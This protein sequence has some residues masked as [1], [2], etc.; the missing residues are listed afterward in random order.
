MLFA[1]LGYYRERF[2]VALNHL[3]YVKY[4]HNNEASDLDSITNIFRHW[5]YQAIYYF[6]YPLTLF[7]VL[8]FGVLSFFCVRLVL[9]NKKSGRFIINSYLILLTLAAL[10]MLYGYF[11]KQRLQDDEYTLS[12]WLMGIAQSPIP[13]IVIIAAHKLIFIQ[14]PSDYEKG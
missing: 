11:F 13:A 4:Y 10:S 14:N 6:K 8:V 2:F 12:R 5:S 1:I 9:N 7:S 3:L